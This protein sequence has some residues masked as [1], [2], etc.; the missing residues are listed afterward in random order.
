MDVLIVEPL[1]SEVLNW[2]AARRSVKVAP[3]LARDPRALRQALFNVRA[4]VAPSSVALDRATLP[5]AP[6]LR[7]VGRL[8]AGSENIDLDACNRAGVEV[9]RPVTASAAAE[10]EFMVGAL[11]QMFRRLP[12]QGESGERVG[13][14]LGGSVIGLIGMTPAAR[15]LAR[16]LEAFGA[17]VIGYD[18]SLHASESLWQQ[19]DVAHC[20]LRELVEQSDGLCVML[21]GFSRYRGLLGE[22]CLPNCKP[23][24]VM[25]SVAP[26]SVF[27]EAVLAR[28]LADGRMAG[29][30]LDS[31]EP[32]TLDPGR[33]LSLIDTL[34]I[35][36]HVAST[37]RESRLRSAW[38]VARRIDAVLGATPARP[39]F[40]PTQP[41]VGLDDWPAA[42]TDADEPA[43]Q[44][45][46]PLD[47]ATGSMPG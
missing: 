29:A 17:K 20:G 15:P 24:Q 27:D 41:G 9:V 13:R 10:A 5:F 36:P 38:S 35:T 33:P 37:T 46:V 19:W 44:P 30:W 26:S 1:E 45:G 43:T 8:S 31:V 39:G 3:G 23:D 21:N 12:V 4:L 2:L 32:G 22:R 42:D 7:A 11:L 14:E 34:Q 25:V 28:V 6:V 16:L 18:P 40:R 47:L